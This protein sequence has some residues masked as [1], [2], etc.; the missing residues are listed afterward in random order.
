VRCECVALFFCQMLCANAD[1][2]DWG[3]NPGITVYDD[4]EVVQEKIDECFLGVSG[5]QALD[6]RYSL[7]LWSIPSDWLPSSLRRLCLRSNPGIYLTGLP[8]RLSQLECLDLSFCDL[9]CK[10]IEVL[11]ES[12]EWLNLEGN[13][14][15]NIAGLSGHGNLSYLNLTG[16]GLGSDQVWKLSTELPECEIVFEQSEETQKEGLDGE[17]MSS[18]PELRGRPSC[19]GSRR[20]RGRKVHRR[21]LGFLIWA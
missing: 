13:S 5:S 11:P 9:T 12:L 2:P 18:S 20:N 15:I 4:F 6:L 17:V 14:G 7:P 21:G 16:C 10:I 3:K 19:M 1:E 8:L